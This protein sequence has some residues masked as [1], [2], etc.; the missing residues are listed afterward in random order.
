MESFQSKSTSA[1]RPGMA[2][3][4]FFL[5]LH[6]ELVNLSSKIRHFGRY[7]FTPSDWVPKFNTHRSTNNKKIT[8][9]LDTKK[10]PETI[11]DNQTPSP[12]E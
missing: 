2:N 1:S 8:T 4:V 9:G 12:R 3:V 10:F 6:R 5:S 7:E 11:W